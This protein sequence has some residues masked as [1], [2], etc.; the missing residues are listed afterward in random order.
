[1]LA[2]QSCLTLC[3]PID[4]SLLGSSVH[5]IPRQKY[6]SGLPFLSPGDLPDP[7]SE[8]GS[9]TLWADSLSSEPPGKPLCFLSELQ[10]N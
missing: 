8:P 9:I 7:G 5:E 2:T 6:W 1:M 3:D 10:M 4:Y